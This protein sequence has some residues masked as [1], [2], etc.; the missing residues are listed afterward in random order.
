LFVAT[1]VQMGMLGTLESGAHNIAISFSG[2]CY[3]LPLGLSFALTARTGQVYGRESWPAIKLRI[4]SGLI[5]TFL[6]AMSTAIILVLF[7]YQLPALYTTDIELRNVAAQLL[8]LAAVFQLSD[9]AQ[10]AFLGILRG[11]QDTRVPMLLNA[12]AYWGVAFPVGFIS[13]HR[14]G[15]GA[16]GLWAGLIIGLTLSAILLA[17]RLYWRVCRA[18]NWTAAGR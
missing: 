2:A 17:W 5:L 4:A 14:L 15:Y 10:V 12:F 18:D 11:L 7:R 6:L 1:A 16:K 13:A 8:V 3:M 9:G